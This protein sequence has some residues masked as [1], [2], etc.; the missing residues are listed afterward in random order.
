MPFQ[1]CSVLSYKEDFDCSDSSFHEDF[2]ASINSPTSTHSFL[3][4][5]HLSCR[6]LLCK[7]DEVLSFYHVNVVDIMTFSETWLGDSVTDLEVCPSNNNFSVFR[8]DRNRRGGGVAI[9]ISN[10]IRYYVCQGVRLNLY[11]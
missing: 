3:C 7:L 10:Q 4:L 2:Y 11:G 5:A 6:S 9:L 8:R 1:D